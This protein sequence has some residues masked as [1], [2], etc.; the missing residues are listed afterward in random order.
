MRDD[1]VQLLAAW[2]RAKK[3]H[4]YR[5]SLKEERGETMAFGERKMVGGRPAFQLD[6]LSDKHGLE[7]LQEPPVFHDGESTSCQHYPC[8]CVRQRTV[9]AVHEVC[10]GMVGY[11]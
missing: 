8:A 5:G 2:H 7:I 11:I 6:H 3:Y 10:T 1:L 4:R 9:D